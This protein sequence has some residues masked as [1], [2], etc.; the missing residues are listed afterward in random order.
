[1]STRHCP[2]VHVTDAA[3]LFLV[4]SPPAGVVNDKMDLITSGVAKKCYKAY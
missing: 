1:M 2:L 4:D 3:M